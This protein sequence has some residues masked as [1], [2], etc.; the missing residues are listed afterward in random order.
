MMPLNIVEAHYIQQKGNNITA[1]LSIEKDGQ[2][3][4]CSAKGN[5]RLDAVS[6]A[7]KLEMGY[8]YALETYTE[9]SLEDMGSGSQAVSYIG[10]KWKN[11]STSWG[12]GLDTDIIRSGI[13]ALVSAINNKPQED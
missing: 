2:M 6:N 4:E 11:G 13:K 12:A 8:S 9:H 3:H 5:C 7:I 1:M 10:L